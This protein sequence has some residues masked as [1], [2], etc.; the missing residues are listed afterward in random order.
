[1]RISDWS[2]DVCSSDLAGCFSTSV[3]CSSTWPA[4]AFSARGGL[5]PMTAKA[6]TDFPEPDS[7]TTQTS[8]PAFTETLYHAYPHQL[9]GGQRQR[10]MIAMALT[11]EPALLIADA[12]TPPP[13]GTPHPQHL[14]LINA[15]R[16]RHGRQAP[17]LTPHLD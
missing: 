16:P 12:P 4:T 10:I 11:L 15:I 13:D 3:P 9:S 17:L 1:M 8:S 5:R 14:A 7:P 6:V 2:S